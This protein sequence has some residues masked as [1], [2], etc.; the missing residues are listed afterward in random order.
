[1][2][3]NNGYTQLPLIILTILSYI[4][5]RFLFV[6]FLYIFRKHAKFRVNL[7]AFVLVKFIFF[8]IFVVFIL[9]LLLLL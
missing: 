7:I 3:G 6:G 8:S 9:S 2:F 1:M 5:V 4:A